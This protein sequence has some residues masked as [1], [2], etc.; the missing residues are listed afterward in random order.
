MRF[1]FCVP[2]RETQNPTRN[3]QNPKLLETQSVLG[4]IAGNGVY[5]FLVAKAARQSGVSSIHVAAFENETQP[6]LS[7]YADSIEWMRV[8]QL[9]RLLKFFERAGVRRAIMAGQIA[10]KNLFDLRPDFKVLMLL[11]ALKKRNAETLFGAVGDEL[12][13]IGIQLL[14]ATTYLEDSLA[15]EGLI[16]GPNPK[17]RSVEDIAFGFEIAKEV[18]K[19]DIGQTVVVR[20]GTVLAVEA[21]E[22]TN[23]AIQRGARLGKRGA[24][25]VKVAK[26]NQDFRFDVPVIGCQTLEIASTAGIK[27]IAVEAGKTLLLDTEAVKALAEEKQITIYGYKI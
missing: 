8:G 7:N 21:F 25:V 4:I 26:P 22:G 19:L 14:P 20:N 5:P 16:A 24:I 3:T 6:E 2:S 10:P 18:S 12:A 9:N 1:A 15:K 17:K 27:V 23:E 11:S 13:K